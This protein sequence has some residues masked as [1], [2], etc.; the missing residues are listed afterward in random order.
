MRDLWKFDAE[1]AEAHRRGAAYT[2]QGAGKVA[3]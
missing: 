3:E 1:K 2:S